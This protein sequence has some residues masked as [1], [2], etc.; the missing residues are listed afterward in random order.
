MERDWS[1]V[2]GRKII[3][4]NKV[5]PSDWTIIELSVLKNIQKTVE[6]EINN[7]KL[8]TVKQTDLKCSKSKIKW[9]LS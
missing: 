1:S 2:R 6:C 3:M 5:K 8:S 4:P 9:V 7:L